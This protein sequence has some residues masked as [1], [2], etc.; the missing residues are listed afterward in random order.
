MNQAPAAR[1]MDAGR[2]PDMNSMKTK[3]IPA[4]E[5]RSVTVEAVIDLAASTNPGKI[6]TAAI[7]RHM[8][9]TQGALFRHFPNKDAIWEAVMKWL[10]DNLFARIEEAAAATDSPL[11]AMEAVFMAHVAFVAEHP[12]APRMLFGELQA[13]RQ[14]PARRV[15]QA[16][17]AGYAARLREMIAAG[18]TR[19][20]LRADLD[21]EAAATLFIGTIQGLVMQSM[22]AGDMSLMT[23]QAPRVFALYQR[24]VEASAPR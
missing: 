17:M 13:A 19:G 2:R 4:A 1:R 20:E 23:G 6:T 24:G 5:R 14:T 21:G 11:G 12:G 18:K 22:I 9:L 3:K 7:A 10:A 16:M 15:A 8:N